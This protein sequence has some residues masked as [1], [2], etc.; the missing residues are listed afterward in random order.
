MNVPIEKMIEVLEQGV[1]QSI[2]REQLALKIKSKKRLR[3]KLG[4][5]PTAP[6]LHLGHTIVL[7]KLRDFQECG[8][9][10]IFL[11]GDFT[12]Q[13]GDPTGKSKTRPPL[14]SGEIKKNAQTYFD[15]VARVL[16]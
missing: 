12:A 9:E 4:L 3:V 13:I 6:D 1:H 16:D 7:Q 10:I 11:I 8:H 14:S 2:S 15:Q 5:D